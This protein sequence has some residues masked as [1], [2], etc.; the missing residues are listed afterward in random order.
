MS[1]R[2]SV[3]LQWSEEDEGFIALVPEIE[4]LSAFGEDPAEAIGELMAVAEDFLQVLAERGQALPRPRT[5]RP[6]SG[7]LRLRLP[8]S[9]HARAALIAEQE[10][11]SLNTFLVACV[12]ESIAL[13]EHG[14]DAGAPRASEGARTT[15]AELMFDL[16]G[17]GALFSSDALVRPSSSDAFALSRSGTLLVQ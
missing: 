1:F 4:G 16:S 10:G 12:A 9:L 2:Y 6:H 15:A 7:Q 8:R 14:H 5:M 3:S 11:V 13:Q 17:D